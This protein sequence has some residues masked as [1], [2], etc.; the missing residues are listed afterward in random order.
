MF[1]IYLLVS[2]L[3][4]SLIAL[5]Y[6]IAPASI[7]PSLLQVDVEGI[8]LTHVFRAV[9]CLYLGMAAYWAAASCI[10][11]WTRPAAAS[12]IFFMSGLALGRAISLVVDGLPSLVL[13]VYLALEIAMA[14]WGWSLFGFRRS[15]GDS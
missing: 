3:G 5:S 1:R 15:A 11:S 9:M 7:I 4:L 2:S 10:P 12:V 13:G 6:G 14:A 8:D